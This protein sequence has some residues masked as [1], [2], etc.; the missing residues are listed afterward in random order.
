MNIFETI[1]LG[2]V[3]GLTEFLPISSSGHLVISQHIL[4]FNEPELLLVSS[5]HLGTLLAVCLYFRDDIKS[6]GEELY[7]LAGHTGEIGQKGK[8]PHASIALWVIVG[9]IPSA[10]IWLFLKE[11]IEVMFGSVP[12]VGF[13]LIFTG[14]ILS[15]ARVTKDRNS[16]RETIGLLIALAVGMAQGLALLP[17]I[18]RSGTTIVCG[19]LLGLDRTFAGRFSFLLSIPAIIGAVLLNFN[20]TE[21]EKVGVT[22]LVIG[23]LISSVVGIISLK[24]LMGMV[25]KGR[26][27]YFTPYC[28]ALGAVVIFLSW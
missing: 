10:V 27:Y 14:L 25:K 2:V 18:S 6:I 3:Q 17:G 7:Y 24:L 20:I 19:L 21:L 15:V 13:M 22:P 12:V 23:F 26:I 8:Y 16:K 1:L 9:S 4:G 5:L 28:L 11:D